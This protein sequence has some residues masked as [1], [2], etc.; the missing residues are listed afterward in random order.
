MLRRVA[1]GELL[2][3]LLVVTD[4][5]FRLLHVIFTDT[6]FQCMKMNYQYYYNSITIPVL[7]ASGT[8]YYTYILESNLSV[9]RQTTY[10]NKPILGVFDSANFKRLPLCE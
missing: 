9:D 4:H 1:G 2:F 3:C 8:C 7:F 10:A 5:I 6:Y